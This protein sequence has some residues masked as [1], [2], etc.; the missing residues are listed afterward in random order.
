MPVDQTVSINL[1]FATPYDPHPS[2]GLE[3]GGRLIYCDML[4]PVKK[5]T[6]RTVPPTETATNPRRRPS[7][8]SA[9]LFARRPSSTTR[10]FLQTTPRLL[11][12]D[13]LKSVILTERGARTR[14]L[15]R[16]HSAIASTA[17]AGCGRR[18]RRLLRSHPSV[19]ALAPAECCA[20]TRRLRRSHQTVAAPAPA[21]CGV[22]RNP[23]RC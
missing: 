4:E 16:P 15:L 2:G 5:R 18:I 22:R 21:R 19:A 3:S 6:R 10:N 7:V 8:Q 13:L 11:S 17:P 14:R 20:R 1:L 23:Q 9:A 12:C